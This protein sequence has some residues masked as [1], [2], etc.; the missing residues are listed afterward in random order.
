M[1]DVVSGV[2]GIVID[3]FLFRLGFLCDLAGPFT[4][5]AIMKS[6]ISLQNLY[7]LPF[8]SAQRTT[9]DILLRHTQ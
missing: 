8:I 6:Y 1:E 7:W 5:H 2:L 9:P 3:D 4:V